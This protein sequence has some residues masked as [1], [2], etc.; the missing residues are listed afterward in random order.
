[1]GRNLSFI[2]KTKYRFSYELL[3]LLLFLI[4]YLLH[5]PSSLAS[6]NLS[7]VPD[8]LYEGSLL[9]FYAK[10]NKFL[11]SSKN[12]F[13]V[14]LITADNQ[15]IILETFVNSKN[16]K[17][18]IRLP[19]LPTD[20]NNVFRVTL[21]TS[22]ADISLNKAEA[23][24]RLLTR[25][26]TNLN[27]NLYSEKPINPEIN[28]NAALEI[29]STTNSGL[30]S[31]VVIGPQGSAGPT[32]P[33]GPAGPQGPIGPAGPVG[34]Q[35]P[36]GP[37]GPTGPAGPSTVTGA[38]VIGP[39]QNAI[40]ATIAQSLLN[41]A[42]SLQLAG[43]SSLVL[44]TPSPTNI[45]LPSTGTLATTTGLTPISLN[46]TP[47]NLNALGN[48]A[49]VSVTGLNFIRITDSTPANTDSNADQLRRLTGGIPGQRVTIL[50]DTSVRVNNSTA[51]AIDELDLAG[52]TNKTFNTKDVLELIY[53]GSL[54][55]EVSRSEN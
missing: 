29:P 35:G 49:S 36:I 4:G 32:G 25:Q 3:G 21:K 2:N 54:W 22:G 12:E 26:A 28:L 31:N 42:N 15:E 47:I 41:G 24:T 34:L 9:T 37:A 48:S 17:A 14:S 19:L 38:N 10:P 45:T 16:N 20:A 50:F 30:F 46:S 40:A 8:V 11:S 7:R 52:T 43:G 13:H 51:F 44:N 39:V 53:D 5:P 1:M 33:A 55:H 27:L 23:I 6:V 18:Q